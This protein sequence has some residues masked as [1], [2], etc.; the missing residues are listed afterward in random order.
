MTSVPLLSEPRADA[1]VVTQLQ[2]GTQVQ[3]VRLLRPR[4]HRPQEAS[5][6]LP[7]SFHLVPV[8]LQT[9]QKRRCLG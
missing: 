3:V 1:A 9:K 2:A 5:A 7:V 8:G 4:E 6:L